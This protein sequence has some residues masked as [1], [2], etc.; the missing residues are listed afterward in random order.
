MITVQGGYES[1][2]F[3][4]DLSDKMAKMSALRLI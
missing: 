2:Y 3:V 4:E 1:P